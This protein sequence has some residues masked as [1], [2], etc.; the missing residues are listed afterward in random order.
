MDALV[1][2]FWERVLFSHKNVGLSAQD[3]KPYYY[4]TLQLHTYVYHHYTR[5]S[6]PAAAEY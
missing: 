4:Y 3:K 5:F 6:K 2:T 1:K